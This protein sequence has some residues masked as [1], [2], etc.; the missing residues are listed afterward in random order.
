MGRIAARLADVAIVTSDNPRS[1]DPLAIIDEMRRRRSRPRRRAGPTRGDR[2][3]DR[4][5]PRRRRRADRGQGER[6][7]PGDRRREASLRRPRGRARVVARAAARVIPLTAGHAPG[8]RPGTVGARRLGGRRHGRRGRLSPDRGG[9]PVRRGRRRGRLHAST[10]SRAAPPRRSC[11][12]TRLPRSPRSPARC[13]SKAA[14]AFV[15]ITGSMGKTSTKDILAAICAVQAR[16]VAAERSFNNEIGVPLTLCRLEPD[17]EICIVEM[18]M[19]GFGQI[20]ELCEFTRPHIGVITNIAP[21]H[22]EKVGDAR[23]RRP[24]EERAHRRA[25]ACRTLRSSPPAFRRPRR[26]RRRP[27]RARA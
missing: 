15:A 22:L 16:T 25:P 9:R 10:H 12:T 17:T 3:G 14:R 24:C 5:R 20:A 11:R 7:G 13:A 26:H 6:A 19:R 21:V 4:G 18:A 8:P 1:E 27:R 2:K 23:R